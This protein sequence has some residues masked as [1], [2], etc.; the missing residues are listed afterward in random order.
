MVADVFEEAE[1]WSAFPNNPSDS[2]P[3]VS[4]VVLGALLAGDGE[5]LARIAANDAIHE[6][7]PACAVEG[8]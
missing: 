8:S 5:W 1:A 3:E 4:R 2:W 7:T 6:S